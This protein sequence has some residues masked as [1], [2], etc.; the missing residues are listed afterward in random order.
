MNIEEQRVI[1]V[2]EP[3]TDINAGF[4]VVLDSGHD[5][6]LDIEGIEDLAAK[7]TDSALE[8][9]WV[10]LATV[11]FEKYRALTLEYLC[12]Y[13][14]PTFLTTEEQGQVI[15]SGLALS[16]LA[17]AHTRY[18]VDWAIELF[19]PPLRGGWPKHGL[20]QDWLDG[21][22]LPLSKVPCLPSSP[23]QVLW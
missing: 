22:A 5:S 2:T 18:T 20:D 6:P 12:H 15:Q 8:K 17:W 3:H 9:F 11:A 7:V 4:V 19:P 23:C 21:H 16:P 10:D 14:D 13:S 1:L